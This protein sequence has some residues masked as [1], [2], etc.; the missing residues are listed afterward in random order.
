MSLTPSLTALGKLTNVALMFLG[1]VGPLT[2]AAAIT[3]RR[4]KADSIRFSF[5]DVVV[6]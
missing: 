2:F 6:G 3:L 1:R 4:R 5:E